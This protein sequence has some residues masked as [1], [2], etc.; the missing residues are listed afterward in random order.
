MSRVGELRYPAGPGYKQAGGTSEQAARAVAGSAAGKRARVLAEVA[1]RG[2]AGAT[3][4]EI[5]QS[6]GLSVLG[7]R[8]R[9]S[10]LHSSGEIV[11]T[12][13]RR[14]NESG[15]LATVWKVAPPLPPNHGRDG[16]LP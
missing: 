12:G 15:L 1:R 3:A 7:V 6:L 8:P 4:D 16:G 9:M 11:A 2:I 5:A 10:E 14:K 13:S